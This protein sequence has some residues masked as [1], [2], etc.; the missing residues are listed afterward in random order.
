MGEMLMLVQ[1]VLRVLKE[2]VMLVQRVLRALKEMVVLVQRVSRAL[3]EVLE[4]VKGMRKPSRA[5][6]GVNCHRFAFL[7]PHLLCGTH[8]RTTSVQE[9]GGEV[10]LL[11]C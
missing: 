11:P 2:M 5:G 9:P 6:K 4:K 8:P 1:R 10:T 7:V 3:K